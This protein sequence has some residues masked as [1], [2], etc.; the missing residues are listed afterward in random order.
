[1]SALARFF[2]ARGA[3]ITG[4][5]KTPTALTHALQQQGME[6]FY[7]DDPNLIPSNCQLVVYTPAVPLNTRLYKALESG[8]LPMMKR[9]KV[10]GMIS[11]KIPTIAVAGTHGKTTIST[12]IAHIMHTAG[13]KF[14]AFL[15][16]ISANYNTNFLGSNQPDWMVVEADEFDRSF[17]HLSPHISVITSMDPDHLDIYGSASSMADSFSRFALQTDPR[18]LLILKKGLKLNQPIEARIRDYHID[19][20]AAHFADHIRVENGTYQARVMG[21]ARIEELVMGLPGKHNLENALAAVAVCHQLGI[22]T[23][24]MARALAGFKGVRRRFEVIYRDEATVYVDDYA[25]HPE[26]LKATL[27]SARELYPGRRITAIFQ[28]HLFS[29]TRDL[30]QGFAESLALADELYLME[31]YPAREL[32][33]P[34]ITSE[35]LLN[36]I[37]MENKKIV[38]GEKALQALM[39]KSPE[40]LLT[41]G[42]GNIDLLVEP[43]KKILQKKDQQ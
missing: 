31:I 24:T 2:H 40:V 17:L 33:I 27:S 3:R 30:V 23:A 9:A 18:G 25:H 39:D 8:G 14:S 37:D 15:G 43:I 38:T 28:P 29:R 36:Q 22:D 32:P 6:V 5:D 10:L 20:A 35:W 41:L 21:L 12:M 16:G 4:Y 19:Q 42:A 11:E 13:M 34:G 1:M 26:E 7:Q